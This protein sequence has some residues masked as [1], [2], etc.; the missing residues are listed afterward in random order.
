MS[1]SIPKPTIWHCKVRCFSS[2][3][4]QHFTLYRTQVSRFF[5]FPTFD[6]PQSSVFFSSTTTNFVICSGVRTRHQLRNRTLCVTKSPHYP[7]RPD[8]STV[9]KYPQVSLVKILGVECYFRDCEIRTPKVA[10]SLENLQMGS[11][12]CKY[13]LNV[14]KYA[15]KVENGRYGRWFDP[16]NGVTAKNPWKIWFNS[17]LSDKW[18]ISCKAGVKY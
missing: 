17:L 14:C 1:R 3:V 13:A 8:S 10:N 5:L 18:H 9:P 12:S 15:W 7:P 4:H 2:L 6:T 16:L 11:K